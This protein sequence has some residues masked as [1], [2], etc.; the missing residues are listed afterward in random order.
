MYVMRWPCSVS[1]PSIFSFY[2]QSV[3]YQVGLCDYIAIFLHVCVYP[4]FSVFCTVHLLWKEGRLLVLFGT[5]YNI[6]H[7]LG[8]PSGP[9]ERSRFRKQDANMRALYSEAAGLSTCCNESHVILL[10]R[11]FRTWND[12]G[13][14]S[15]HCLSS[16]VTRQMAPCFN[17]ESQGMN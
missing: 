9:T 15:F 16:D 6:I 10:L 2:K 1:I 14:S 5:S 4:N 12:V 8:V 13:R 11:R 17:E 3:S 7:H